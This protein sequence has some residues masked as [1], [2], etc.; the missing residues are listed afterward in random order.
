L[1]KSV[2]VATALAVVEMT[3]PDTR[4]DQFGNRD[5]PANPLP[6]K[7]PHC[8][9]PDLDAVA[10]PYLLAKGFAAPAEHAPA[11]VGN[12]LVRERMRKILELVAPGACTFHP[13]AEKKS[14]KR[15]DWFLAVPAHVI[16]VPGMKEHDEKR[17]RCGKCKAPKLGYQTYSRSRH[18]AVV[19]KLSAGVDVFKSKQWYA[20]QTA[21]D[22]LNGVNKYRKKE[23]MEPLDWSAY[24]LT[25]PPH[26]QRWTRDGVSRDLYFSVRLEQ[27]LKK[28]KVKGQLVRLLDFQDVKPTAE[29]LAWIDEKLAQL[30]KHGLVDAP[31]KK[32]AKGKK[33][34]DG[35]AKW[36]AQYLK[37][38]AAKKKPAA[39]DF[40]AI[41]K[42]HKVT[43][44]HDY[45]DFIATVGEK[46]FEDVMEQE[47]F[48][49]RVVG[50]KKI[51]FRDYRCGKM[52]D[53]L[54]DEESLAV[55]G[56]M[57]ADTEHGDAFVFDLA[58]RDA[59]G[60]YPVYW[61]DH[62]GNA[63]EAFAPTFAA[64]IKRFVERT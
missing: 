22:S 17:E 42:K 49:A 5:E 20:G 3:G 47:G 43:L 6:V 1:G 29:D 25:A 55:D 38:N 19:N 40:E 10:K 60:N 8:T 44:P 46:Q 12:F 63:M 28:A 31:A 7:C 54:F 4:M 18:V 34:D 14:K 30:A 2:K 21:E 27:L 13:T 56:V 35:T 64:C 61:Y 59:A 53:L 51:D 37:N 16:E 50:P 15:T 57:F 36:F 41:E 52:T 26:P 11:E 39:I 58:Q 9:M 48:T 24:G 45:K 62:E 32:A 33:P 23:G